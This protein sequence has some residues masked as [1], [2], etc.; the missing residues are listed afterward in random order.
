MPEL[1]R[2]F[3]VVVA[4]YYR[5][6]APPHL[7]AYFGTDEAI[8]EM[9]YRIESARH[10]RAFVVHLRFEDG[11]EGDVD[12]ESELH[13]PVFDPLRDPEVFVRLRV[14]PTLRTLVWPNGADFAPEFLRRRLRR[15]VDAN[16][17]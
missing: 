1:S 15:P 4:M 14:H 13:G 12:L 9:N 6:H 17:N 16:R 5:D 7:H 8:V 11:A 3:G 2:F 10:V